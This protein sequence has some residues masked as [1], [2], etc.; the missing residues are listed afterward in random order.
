MTDTVAVSVQGYLID[1]D[2]RLTI[3]PNEIDAARIDE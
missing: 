2:N 1:F 3:G